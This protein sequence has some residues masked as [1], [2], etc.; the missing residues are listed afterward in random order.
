[1]RHI[2]AIKIAA[3]YK[4]TIMYFLVNIHINNQSTHT[5]YKVNGVPYW[6]W[7]N[8]SKFYIRGGLN[9]LIQGARPAPLDEVMQPVQTLQVAE[10]QKQPHFPLQVQDISVK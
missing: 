7:Y 9:Y 8:F 3:T 2:R 1:M 10:F 4:M 6:V 5:L